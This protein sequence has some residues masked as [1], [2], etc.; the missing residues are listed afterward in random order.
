VLERLAALLLACAPLAAQAQDEEAYQESPRDEQHDLLHVTA[1]GGS[2]FDLSGHDSAA[3][4]LGGEVALA[5]ESVDIGVLAQ[6]YHLGL[7]RARSP[8]APVVMARLLQRF[9]TR[10]G[11]EATLGF[12]LGA[13]RTTGWEGWFQL[14]LGVRLAAGPV[15]FAGEVGFEQLNLFRLAA[16]V[17]FRI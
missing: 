14:A 2:L 16:G 8:W 1:W 5:F 4:L 9:E 7:S 3:A 6:G 17:G 12:G 15:F 13:A 11:I 10:R